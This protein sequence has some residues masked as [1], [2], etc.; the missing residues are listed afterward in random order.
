MKRN[1]VIVES[2]A[3]SKTIGKFLGSDYEIK[4]SFGHVRD[5]PAYRLGVNIKENFEPTYEKLKKKTNVLK[6]LKTAMEKV[7]KIYLATDPDREGEAI[8]WHIK[9]ALKIPEKKF[10]RITFNEITSTAIKNAIKNSRQIDQNL[11]DAQQAR[12]VLDRLIGY[13]LSPI[14]SKKIRKGLSAGRVQSIAVKLI[15]DRE[16]EINSFIKEEF[17]TIDAELTKD[18]NSP[19]FL[20]RLFAKENPKTKLEIKDENN[21]KTL[22][23]I[24]EK[25]NYQVKEIK[26]SL[27]NRNAP[28]PFITSTLQQEAVKKFNWNAT[29]TMLIAQQLYE[30]L[31]IDSEATS[32][33]TYMRTDS[34][35]I[36]DSAKEEALN[37]IKNNF[38]QAYLPN[39]KKAIKKKQNVQDAHEAIRPTYLKL[40]PENLKPKISGDHFKLYKLIWERFMASQMANAILENTQIIISAETKNKE[41]YFLKTSGNVINFDGFMKIYLETKEETEKNPDQELSNLPKLSEKDLLTLI[42]LLPEQ[43]FTQPPPRYTE[44]SL[45]KELEEKGIGRPSTYAPTINTILDREYV[46]KEKKAFYITELGNIVTDQ[47]LAYFPNILNINFTAK[48]ESELDEIMEGKHV[49][50]DIIKDFY[51]PFEKLINTAYQEMKKI[52]L[53]KPTDEVCEKCNSPMVIKTGR[54]GEFLACSNYPNCKNTKSIKHE[55]D[56][57]CPE[58]N[59]KIIERKT[60]KNK[61]FYGCSNYPKCKFVSWDKPIQEKCPSCNYPI[62]LVKLNK[63]N[64][65]KYCPKCQNKRT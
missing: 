64:E 59:G 4:A 36:A 55:L 43:R 7:E 17:W 3:K 61:T 50:Q 27:I 19:K 44:A 13:L 38:G 49:W 54:F 30:G 12:R 56:V 15:Y 33:I 22:S 11:V 63:N 14:L 1:L 24:L 8:A 29:K 48:M 16:K 53:D 39:A 52:N 32:L 10:S 57:I 65:K 40:T 42:K 23:Q 6:E 58:C 9:E 18:K 35:R 28:L 21:A 26:K 31:D 62:L 60:K 37:Y 25:A 2:P 51:D 46:K 41:T 5:L 34:I 20:A 47:L 45:I